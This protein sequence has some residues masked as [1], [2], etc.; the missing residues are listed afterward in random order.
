MQEGAWL[1][2]LKDAGQTQDGGRA[3]SFDTEHRNHRAKLLTRHV[4]A[5]SIYVPLVA[6]SSRVSHRSKLWQRLRMLAK[7]ISWIATVPMVT[8][9]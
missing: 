7:P 6:N 8:L 4:V 5:R 3:L 2:I 1:S 9:S